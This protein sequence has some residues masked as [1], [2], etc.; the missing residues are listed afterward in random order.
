M[1]FAIFIAFFLLETA[2]QNNKEG[3]ITEL[4]MA[5]KFQSNIYVH[6]IAISNPHWWE[7]NVLSK[8]KVYK[9]TKSF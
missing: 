9:R 8:Q 4:S 5:L 6:D 1:N 7:I 2:K 3:K